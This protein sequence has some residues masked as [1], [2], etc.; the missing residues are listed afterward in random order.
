[1]IRIQ[2]PY[3]N[4]D[5]VLRTI[6]KKAVPRG[7]IEYYKT[8]MR[9]KE[10]TRAIEWFHTEE[11]AGAIPLFHAVEIETINRCNGEC[12]FCPVSKGHDIRKM[13]KMEDAVFYKIIDELSSMNYSGNISLFSNNEP[14]I[15]ER[16]CGFAKYAKE[17]LP[18]AFLYLYTNGTLL[19]MEKYHSIIPFLDMMFIDNYNDEMQ[20]IPT[21][22]EIVD[23][24]A[25]FHDY[26]NKTIVSM[27]KINEVLT[28]RGG[29]APN[30]VAREGTI[31]CPCLLPY[32]QLIIR[33]T[34]EVSLCCNDCYGKMTM[35]DVNKNTLLEIWESDQYK[36]IRNMITESRSN[37]ELCKYCDTTTGITDTENGKWKYRVL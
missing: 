2:N 14:F 13:H 20:L 16:I 27:R 24:S 28:S 18:D 26:E 32:Q 21:V 33:P 4:K 23:E 12:P 35:G 10:L 5:G 31:D 8:A 11:R 22:K 36:K 6:V 17:H 7:I 3:Q 15:D 30:K 25:S 37:L 34:G 1:M 29:Q 9:R 19:T